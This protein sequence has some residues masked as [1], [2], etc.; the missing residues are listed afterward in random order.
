MKKINLSKSKFMIII[1]ICLIALI[2]IP[3]LFE[4]TGYKENMSDYVNFSDYNSID[5]IKITD[6]N[7]NTNSYAYCIGGTVKCKSSTETLIDISSS[8]YTLGKTYKPSCSNGGNVICSDNLFST[9]SEYNL[10]VYHINDTSFP[11]SKLYKGFTIPYDYIPVN[12]DTSNNFIFNLDRSKTFSDCITQ[13]TSNNTQITT[14]N[15]VI[16]QNLPSR[17]TPTKCQLVHKC[18]L[19]PYIPQQ[20][21]YK[22]FFMGESSNNQKTSGSSG[23][24]GTSGSSG[25][26]GSSVKSGTSGTN[27]T[28]KCVDDTNIKC[29]ADFGTNIGDEL[30][31]GQTG[32]LQNTKYVCPESRPT[33]SNFKCGSKFGKC[34]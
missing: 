16:S 9:I 1:F 8:D 30:C 14:S 18:N 6:S 11:L 20:A 13:Y 27:N 32:V 29:I 17:N 2:V 26:S 12:F 28:D 15:N 31:C 21:C 4:L 10:D 34:Q 7:T 5:R 24:S 25:I 33:C 22:H 3:I 23:S 19:L